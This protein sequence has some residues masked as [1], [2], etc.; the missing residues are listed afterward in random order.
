[1]I[2]EYTENNKFHVKLLIEVLIS[3]AVR[4]SNN[5]ILAI[6]KTTIDIN[7]NTGKSSKKNFRDTEQNDFFKFILKLPLFNSPKKFNKPYPIQQIKPQIKA[8]IMHKI[9]SII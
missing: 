1:M 8:M 7:K 4:I 3:I 2:A 5:G 9:K 6:A